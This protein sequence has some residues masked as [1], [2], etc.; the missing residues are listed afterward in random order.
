VF[1]RT[2]PDIARLDGLL[3]PAA[4]VKFEFARFKKPDEAVKTSNGQTRAVEF[5]DMRSKRSPSIIATPWSEATVLA[6][7]ISPA[8][9]PNQNFGT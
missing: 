1:G 7:Y 5:L 4:P 3:L 6:A 9:P 2:Q 8:R